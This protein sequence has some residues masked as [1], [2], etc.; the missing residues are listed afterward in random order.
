MDS[1]FFVWSRYLYR[2]LKIK[3]FSVLGVIKK[4]SDIPSQNFCEFWKQII[5]NTKRLS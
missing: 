4:I 3:D 5:K 2:A 1:K